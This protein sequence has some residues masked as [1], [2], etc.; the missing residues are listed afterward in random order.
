MHS[1]KTTLVVLILLCIPFAI[2]VISISDGVQMLTAEV[3]EILP[4]N[5]VLFSDG[6]YTPHDPIEIFGDSELEAMA[7]SG[8]GHPFNPYILGGWNITASGQHAIFIS[9]TSECFILQDCWLNVI[10]TS[11]D[12]VWIDYAYDYSASVRNLVCNNGRYGIRVTDCRGAVIYNNTCLNSR[13]GIYIQ[14]CEESEVTEN[15]CIFCQEIG[16]YFQSSSMSAVSGNT[17]TRTNFNRMSSQ[18]YGWGRGIYAVTNA[19]TYFTNNSLLENEY[20]GMLLIN[21]D[22]SE[23]RFNNVTGGHYIGMSIQD[24]PSAKVADNRVVANQDTGLFIYDTISATVQRNTISENN[25]GMSIS[26]CDSVTVVDNNFIRDGLNLYASSAADY[27]TYTLSGNIINGLPY[28]FFVNDI[29]G[30]ILTDYGQ[31]L[32]VNCTGTQILFQNCSFTSTGIML[33]FCNSCAI[34]VSTCSNNDNYGINAYAS[35]HTILSYVTCDNNGAGGAY[36][37]NTHFSTISECHFTGNKYGIELASHSNSKIINNTISSS[38]SYGLYYTSNTNTT[39]S[40]NEFVNDG[41]KFSAFSDEEWEAYNATLSNN[42]VNNRPLAI[43]FDV[44]DQT[45]TADYGQLVLV[46]CYHLE[47]SSKNLSHTTVGL[48]LYESAYISIQNTDFTNCKISGLFARTTGHNVIANCDFS[49]AGDE[50]IDI[51]HS[52][53]D[54]IRNC[55]FLNCT[56]GMRLSTSGGTVDS[57]LCQNNEYGILAYDYSYVIINNDCSFNQ[58]D[59]IHISSCPSSIIRNN[60]CVG[61]LYDGFSADECSN[62]IV[63]GNNFSLNGYNGIRVLRTSTS[64]FIENYCVMNGRN[65]IHFWYMTEPVI[66]CQASWN[67]LNYNK[68]YGIYLDTSEYCTVSYN[69]IMNNALYGVHCH[70]CSYTSVHHCY[71]LENNE[72]GVQG[73]DDGSEQTF[74]YDQSRGEGNYW[75]DL[76]GYGLYQIDGTSLAVDPFPFLAPDF[77]EDSLD[78]TWEILNGLNPLSVDSDADSMSDAYEVAYG[79]DPTSDDSQGDLDGDLLSNLQEYALGTRPD[80]D[81]SDSDLIDDFWEWSNN[82]NP[83]LDDA[84]NDPDAD[85][86]TNLGEY[87]HG[88]GPHNPDSDSDS[89]LDGFEVAYGLNPLIDDS[90][91]D[92]DDDTL[93]NLQEYILGLNPASNDSDGDLMDDAFEIRY[94]LNPLIDD[95]GWDPDGDGATNLEEYLRGTNPLVPDGGN[96]LLLAAALLG[97]G[98]SG[99]IVAIIVVLRWR[100]RSPSE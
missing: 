94:Y 41:I 60:T 22:G 33:R 49:G 14:S 24:C 15:E 53:S 21:C 26:S 85:L 34:S 18:T 86:L 7:S 82:L 23:I 13:S 57:N 91:G 8:S 11:Y 70:V 5:S 40:G 72:G 93:T 50:G 39:V 4:S 73:L 29:D 19:F 37:Q 77:D 67:W 55:I 27:L 12:C 59:G 38:E 62:L 83:L 32:L 35:N 80:N 98:F 78:D 100:S 89:M 99:G 2:S 44:W 84:N 10:S 48:E 28:G 16:I 56:Y 45:L 81:D 74:W 64:S 66:S 95:S 31:L 69:L 6:N 42:Y 75:S 9:G 96:P 46:D 79:L 58:G 25:G 3:P 52:N 76:V 92:L 47:I 51:A 61:N 1:P 30:L 54:E 65:G 90:S 71:F 43:L 87:L 20:E 88:T 97:L 17:C 63:Q 36:V 68:D